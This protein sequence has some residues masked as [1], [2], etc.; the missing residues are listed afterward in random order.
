MYRGDFEPSQ[1]KRMMYTLMLYEEE[2]EKRSML[3]Y[4]ARSYELTMYRV[5]KE[6]SQQV[7]SAVSCTSASWGR[8]N[9]TTH[10]SRIGTR[11]W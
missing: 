4:P 7:I 3:C 11:K 2:E 6:D 5:L 9:V 10:S 8:V 1:H